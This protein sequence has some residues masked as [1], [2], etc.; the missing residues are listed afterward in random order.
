M[1]RT[2]SAWTNVLLKPSM[3]SSRGGLNLRCASHHAPAAFVASFDQTL[4]MVE[5]ILG[6]KPGTPGCLPS[7]VASLDLAAGRPDWI[8]VE[9]IDVPL[10]QR[11]L[12]ATIDEPNFDRLLDTSTTTR[13]RALTLSSA[14]QHA[15]DWLNVLPSPTLGLHLHSNEFRLCLRYWLGLPLFAVSSACP[16]CL[17]P[18]DTF[19]DHQVGCGGNGDRVARHD[20]LRNAIFTAAQ[21]AALGP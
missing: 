14:L 8:S 9:D 12:S 1:E 10:C 5:K 16:Q 6:V 18:A 19:G 11:V 4:P 2:S 3:P 17:R 21:S 13:Q 20:A 7:T 15:G